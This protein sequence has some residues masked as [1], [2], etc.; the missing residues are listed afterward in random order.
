M[1]RRGQTVVGSGVEDEAR[2]GFPG[3]MDSNSRLVAWADVHRD[4]AVVVRH[5]PHIAAVVVP[6][7]LLASVI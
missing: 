1:A 4:L 5:T 6:R 7:F 2:C 3:C